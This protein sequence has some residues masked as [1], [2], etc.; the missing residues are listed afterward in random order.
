MI[1]CSLRGRHH[2]ANIFHDKP[3]SPA[4][5]SPWKCIIVLVGCVALQACA[6]GQPLQQQAT[7]I[8]QSLMRSDFA[9]VAAQDTAI[10]KLDGKGGG[11]LLWELNASSAYLYSGNPAKAVS[12]LDFA[13]A[14]VTKADTTTIKLD[15]DYRPRV[16]DMMMVNSYKALGFLGA[17]DKA[18]ARVEFN[19]ADDRLRRAEEYYEKEVAAAQSDANAKQAKGGFD[20]NASMQAVAA[21]DDYQANARVLSAFGRY[22][23]FVNPVQTYLKGIFLLNSDDRSDADKARADLARVAGMVD[24]RAEVQKDVALAEQ[25]ARGRPVPPTVWVLFENGQSPLLRPY[26]VTF[27]VPVLGGRGVSAGIVTVALP[28]FEPQALAYQGFT[29]QAGGASQASFVLSDFDNVMGA[30]FNKRYP[31]I[32]ASAVAEVATKIVLQSAANRSGN[33]VL[34]LVALVGSQISTTDTR[35]WSML[36]KRFD[37]ARV[38]APQDGRLLIQPA[39]GAPIIVSIPP[40]KAAIVIVKA[41]RPG[42]PM[43]ANAYPL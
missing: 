27:P 15:G 7:T 16:Y 23:L 2:G 40:G 6:G 4:D 37:A 31:S 19:R 22:G 30:E 32:V 13:E 8:E 21:N 26:N 3:G 11:D 9:A 5:R 42:S 35:S 1:S 10:G 18:N 17:N 24:A 12:Y 20:L 14:A 36:P 28:K 29:V 41:M 25:H 38:A 43:V 39:G 33:G 34:Q